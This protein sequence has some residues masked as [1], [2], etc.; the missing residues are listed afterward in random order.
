VAGALA[1]GAAVTTSFAIVFHVKHHPCAFRLDGCFVT[2]IA[3]KGTVFV[4]AQSADAAA[5]DPKISGMQDR[6]H[7]PQA[8]GTLEFTSRILSRIPSWRLDSESPGPLGF[9]A[10][11]RPLSSPC[12]RCGYHAVRDYGAQRPGCG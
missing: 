7:A 9:V 2:S 11:P 8:S 4:P 5:Q 1:A 3:D 12:D 10:D 6:W